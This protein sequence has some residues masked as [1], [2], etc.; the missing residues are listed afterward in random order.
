M[1]EPVAYDR[2]L[3]DPH[4]EQIVALLNGIGDVGLERRDALVSGHELA[5]H[6]DFGAA[7]DALESEFD[8]ARLRSER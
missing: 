7:I 8:P 5:V 4:G 2:M 3:S 6:P 1:I